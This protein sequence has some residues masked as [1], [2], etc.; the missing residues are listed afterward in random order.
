MKNTYCFLLITLVAL[1]AIMCTPKKETNANENVEHFDWLTG[2]WK[3]TN[4]KKDKET[5]ENWQK[6]SASEYSGLGF[7]MQNNDTISQ[8]QMKLIQTGGI[9]NLLVIA[10]GEKEFTRFEMSDIGKEMFECKND[11]L[12]FPK[13]ILYRK[14][15]DKISAVISGD[16]ME[17]KYE[18]EKIK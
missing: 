7:T 6:I 18:F 4:E 5:F 17:I 9:W 3:R 10:P 1:T 12:D 15:G 14:N 13:R 2:N 16:D 8:E 11:T